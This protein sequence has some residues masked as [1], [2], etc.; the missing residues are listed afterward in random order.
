MCCHGSRSMRSRMDFS[1]ILQTTS[2]RL[3]KK[4]RSKEE[5]VATIL[6]AARNSATKTRIMRTCYISYNLLQKYL[7]YAT[8][9]GLLFY[10]SRSNK[11]H[12]TSKGIQYLDYFDQYLD[13]ESELVLKKTLISTML[14]NNVEC[15]M[16]NFKSGTMACWTHTAS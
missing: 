8:V 7:N 1:T 13:T 6:K 4:H 10:D 16:P 11:Y 3:Y 2:K 5:I 9:N 12:I 14:E 15:T